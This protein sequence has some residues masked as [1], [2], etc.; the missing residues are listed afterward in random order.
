MSLEYMSGNKH[1]RI[2]RV[3]HYKVLYELT[4]HRNFLLC[5]YF[6]L[7]GIISMQIAHFYNEGLFYEIMH[8]CERYHTK[9]EDFFVV[10]HC[11]VYLAVTRPHVTK[12]GSV[13]L[14]LQ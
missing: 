1:S 8:T 14:L 13:F 10:C 2:V 5:Q 6:F 4:I 7:K 9:D 3:K 12:T 11:C